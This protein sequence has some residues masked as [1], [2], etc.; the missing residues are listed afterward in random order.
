MVSG[1]GIAGIVFRFF[2][3]NP[4]SGATTVAQ[5]TS[6]DVFEDLRRRE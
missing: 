4:M 2:D 1:S 3:S 6:R 5:Q